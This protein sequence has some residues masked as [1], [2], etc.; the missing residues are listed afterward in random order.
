VGCTPL[1]F[2][3][4]WFSLPVASPEAVCD[5]LFFPVRL[6]GMCVQ[7]SEGS[8]AALCDPV[9]PVRSVVRLSLRSAVRCSRVRQGAGPLSLSALFAVCFR[10]GLGAFLFLSSHVEIL[11]SHDARYTAVLSPPASCSPRRRFLPRPARVGGFSPCSAP[12]PPAPSA[13]RSAAPCFL[14]GCATG[15]GASVVLR[16][17]CLAHSHDTAAAS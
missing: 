17:S 3:A 9:V 1:P 10:W 7:P 13:P 5:S 8:H 11:T 4:W 14:F 15:A 2:G 16:E 6:V 12:A